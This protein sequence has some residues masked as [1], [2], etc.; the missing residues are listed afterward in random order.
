MKKSGK[1]NII[2]AMCRQA[3]YAVC[4]AV[5]IHECFHYAVAKIC[6]ADPRFSIQK[7]TPSVSFKNRHNDLHNLLVALA[8][9]LPLVIIGFCLIN[10]INAHTTIFMLMCLTNVFNLIPVTAD[11]QVILLSI[12][13]MIKSRS[14]SR[15]IRFGS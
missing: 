13:N 7:L 10:R 12:L 9:P 6:G 5:T 15:K 14:K 2:S 4:A 11:G 1:Q 8:G 3:G